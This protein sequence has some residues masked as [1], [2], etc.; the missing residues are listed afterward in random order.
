MVSETLLHFSPSN[1]GRYIG[2]PIARGNT[3]ARCGRVHQDQ[4]ILGKLLGTGGFGSV[5]VAVV[6]G[7]TVAVKTY[8]KRC[9]NPRALHQSY[10]SELMVY[11]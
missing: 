8:H 2:S 10:N 1:P 6:R 7:R 11:R 5:Y 3:P 9:S 4:I